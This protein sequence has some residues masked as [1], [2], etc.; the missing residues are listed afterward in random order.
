[1]IATAA[2]YRATV[3]EM[4]FAVRWPDGSRQEFYSPSLI[5]EEYLEPGVEYPVSDFVERCR[6]SLTIASDRVRAKYG[7]GCAESA[8]SL[9]TIERTAAAFTD[10][11]VRV[12]R[13]RR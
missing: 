11:D 6:A 2:A 10:G 13:F 8:I 9:A 1:M 5:V 12:E 7:M 4:L 3:P